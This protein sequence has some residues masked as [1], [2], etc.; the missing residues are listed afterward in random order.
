MSHSKNIRI[1]IVED[2]E[3]IGHGLKFNFESEGY[4]V[5]LARNGQDGLDYI[6]THHE[7][8]AVI[9]LDLMLP[10]INGYEVLKKTREFAKMIP[11]LVLSAKSLEKDKVLAFELGAD[12]Y[13]TKPFSLMELLLRVKNL[14]KKRTWEPD[15]KSPVKEHAFGKAIF[16]PDK[17]LVVTSTKQ[18]IRVSPTEGELI[19]LFY[20]SQNKILTRQELLETVWNYPGG[21]HIETRTVDVFI[22]KLRRYM[23][24]DPAHPVFLKS[25]RG[26]GYLYQANP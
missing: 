12:D 10:Q 20:Q 5:H 13:V 22:G 17:L 25:I 16:Y 19:R 3:A 2:E 18:E 4:H 26:K 9:I 15:S 21:L 23:E 1:L 24:E 6:K 8:L 7:D 11:I 14:A